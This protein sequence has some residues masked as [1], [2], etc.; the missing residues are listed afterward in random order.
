MELTEE[1]ISKIKEQIIHQIKSTFP[2]NKKEEAIAQ[3]Q[4]MN[5]TEFME[6]LEKNNLLTENLS[7]SGG[8]RKCIFCSIIFGDIPSTK[9]GE[10]DKAIAILEI[11][12]IS[13]GHS[14]VIP[15]AHVE[16]P[17][18]LDEETK[19]LAED[20]SK[21]LKKAFNPKEVKIINGN[22]T[23]HEILNVLPVYEEE[24]LQSP[25]ANRSPEELE[26][27]KKEILKFVDEKEEK[28]KEENKEIYNRKNFWL[29]K[30]IP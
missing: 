30:R 6:F 17:E 8:E 12:P 9:I 21:I 7:D 14:L 2:E 19:N 24:T 28:P 4:S 15:K 27:I 3:I 25:R 20:L 29:P 22:V 10:N 16:K 13:K 1:Q 26:E 23:G 5:N 18:D 11:N